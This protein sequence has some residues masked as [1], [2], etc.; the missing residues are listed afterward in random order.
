MLSTA[1]SLLPNMETSVLLL[2]LICSIFQTTLANNTLNPTYR[3]HHTNNS[4]PHTHDPYIRMNEIDLQALG[5]TDSYSAQDKSWRE[6]LDIHWVNSS[7]YEISISWSLVNASG[8]IKFSSVE[9]FTTDGKFS[10]HL[11]KS[12]VR[13]YTF[14]NL[15]PATLYTIC[16]YVTEAIGLDN[17]TEK[18]HSNCVKINTIDY[19]RR[20]SLVVLLLTVGYFA[21][22][23]LLGYSQW[24]RKLCTIAARARSKSRVSNE[25]VH[26]NSK[27]MTMR[28][29]DL[30]EREHLMTS[31]KGVCSIECNDT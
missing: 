27:D 15:E 1:L 26:R 16:V 28:Y 10:S 3:V 11:L 2:I 9:Y 8:F 31:R 18:Y 17:S 21:F 6:N 20:D 19:I 5:A 25:D 24:R 14:V 23:A 29:R 30:E 13:N 12:E 22:M 4:A 7:V